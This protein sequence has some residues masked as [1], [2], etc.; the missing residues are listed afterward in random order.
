MINMTF[1]DALDASL[2]RFDEFWLWIF[3]IMIAAFSY[4]GFV[5]A[6]Y[7]LAVMIRGWHRPADDDDDDTT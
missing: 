2:S 6:L 4:R 3:W 1:W 7:Y 5:M